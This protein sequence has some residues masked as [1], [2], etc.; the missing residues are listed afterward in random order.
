MGASKVALS[1][2]VVIEIG[3][4]SFKKLNADGFLNNIP[5]QSNPSLRTLL[6]LSNDNV[7]TQRSIV[8]A[9]H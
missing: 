5:I 9:M 6:E 1:L 4:L 2:L 8:Y 3:E 7:F